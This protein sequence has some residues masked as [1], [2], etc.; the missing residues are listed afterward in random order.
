MPGGKHI[1]IKFI[2]VP[3]IRVILPDAF[4]LPMCYCF[5]ACVPDAFASVCFNSQT[6]PQLHWDQMHKCT[7]CYLQ[8]AYL[9][10]GI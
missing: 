2:S 7:G 8:L 9:L 1:S 3:I 6:D 5:L 10:A 4:A